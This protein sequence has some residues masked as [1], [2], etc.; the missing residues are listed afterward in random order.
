M[1]ELYKKYF[2]NVLSKIWIGTKE[3]GVT[4]VFDKSF[5]EDIYYQAQL[6]HL[7]LIGKTEK[8]FFIL[9]CFEENDFHYANCLFNN[10]LN[11]LIEGYFL[12]AK[13]LQGLS[14][15]SFT[16]KIMF[17]HHLENNLSVKKE[18]T[19]KKFKI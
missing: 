8:F 2:D 3:I 13:I 7:V 1:I 15:A 16:Q 5:V 9:E 4:P 10:D 17:N 18:S 14:I 6:P 19:P 12:K 11:K